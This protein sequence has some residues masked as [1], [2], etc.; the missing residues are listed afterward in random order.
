L[1]V[2]LLFLR[3]G[4][5]VRREPFDRLAEADGAAAGYFRLERVK[6]AWD[7]QVLCDVR[8]CD[9]LAEVLE[10]AARRL[11]VLARQSRS[12]PPGKNGAMTQRTP[13]SICTWAGHYSRPIGVRV[14]SKINL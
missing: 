1:L 10:A 9:A 12:Q 8:C 2:R 4:V 13:R 6:P 7:V 5:G 14:S 3:L 11:R